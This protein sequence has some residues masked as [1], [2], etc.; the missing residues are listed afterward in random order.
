M[1][2]RDRMCTLHPET[3]EEDI[4]N[5]VRLLCESRAASMG[6]CRTA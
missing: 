3:T 6:Q 4:R 5:T 1:C 2:I